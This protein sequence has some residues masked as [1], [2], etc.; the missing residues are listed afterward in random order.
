VKASL[1]EKRGPTARISVHLD[2]EEV[3]R[4][5]AEVT[6][7]LRGRVD[8]PG[9]RQGKAPRRLV[10][11]HLGY[12]RVFQEAISGLLPELMGRAC[13]ELGL[14]PVTFPRVRIQGH[15]EGGDLNMEATVDLYPE[16]RLGDYKSLRVEREPVPPVTEEEVEK[17]LYDLQLDAARYQPLEDGEL[18]EG[19]VGT[20]LVWAAGEEK[21]R[22]WAAVPFGRGVLP[23]DLEEVLKGARKGEEREAVFD[24]TPVRIRVEELFRQDLPSLDE[25]A[26]ELGLEGVEELRRAVRARLEDTRREEAER[27]YERRIVDEIVAS[28]ELELPPGLVEETLREMVKRREPGR[29]EEVERWRQE[30]ESWV[31]RNLVMEEVARREGVTVEETEVAAWMARL[32]A[33]PRHAD[34]VRKM[35]RRRK[36][37]EILKRYAGG[38]GVERGGEEDAVPGA[39]GGGAD[40]PGGESV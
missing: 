2:A 11:R 24:D 34:E 20:F 22:R 28:A 7:R 16:I 5:V 35:L 23:P 40:Q 8:I 14:E 10:I 15:V 18:G 21:P 39:H 27:R 4:A 3:A 36:T 19:L 17:A 12:E 30:A 6:E 26:G 38:E 1:E 33:D 9:F 31:R 29:G 13:Q 32:G 37:I 25:V